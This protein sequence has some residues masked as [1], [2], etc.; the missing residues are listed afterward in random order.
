MFSRLS[1]IAL[2]LL[3]LCPI[4][5]ANESENTEKMAPWGRVRSLSELRQLPLSK[6]PPNSLSQINSVDQLRDVQPNAWAYEAL[7]S[8]VERYGCIVGYPDATFRG[9]RA[10]SRWEFA[11]GLNACL[12]TME[13]L[14]QENVAV[15]REDIDKLKRLAQDFEVELAALGTRVDNLESRVAYLEDH[16]F[17]TTTK[18]QGS[19]IFSVADVFGNDG[20]RNETVLQYRANLNFVTSFTGYDALITSL[21]AGNAPL[22]T[23]FNLPATNVPTGVGPVP[24]ETAEG[25]LSSQ[26]AGNTN[27]SLQILALQYIFPVGD[28]L[29]VD[30]ASSLSAWQPFIPTLNPLLDDASGGR[31]TLSEFGQRNPIY[32]LGGGGTGIMFNYKLADSLTLSGSYL[33]NGLTVSNPGKNGGLFNGSYGALGQLTWNATESFAIAAVYLNKYNTPGT[34]G[35]NYNSL[36]VAGTAVTNTLAGQD[37]PFGDRVGSSQYPVISNAIG[38]NFSWKPSDAVVLNGWFSTTN[39]RLIGQGDGN[40]L[41]YAMTLGFPDLGKEGNLLGFVFGAQPYLT[42]FKGGNPQPFKVDVPVHLEAFYR[43]QFNNNISLTP[44]LIWLLA[45]NQDRDNASDVIGVLRTTFV[46]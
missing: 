22:R 46:F 4:V 1:L 12:N 29:T 2:M 7:K 33:A 31:G 44:G 21:F 37:I 6:N 8:L 34:F 11:A 38:A 26:F 45:P 35:F 39:A 43:Y 14:L 10:L 9:D 19:T 32:A 15:L 41:T 27:N 24:I 3:G 25:T 40:I 30:I 13:K 5:L 16:Q 36:G 20:N 28:R 17:S 42:S 18:L 23:S